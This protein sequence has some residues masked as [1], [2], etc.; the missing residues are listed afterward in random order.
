M[1]VSYRVSVIPVPSIAETLSGWVAGG[2]YLAA[3]RLGGLGRDSR[4]VELEAE[5]RLGAG[6]HRV[7]STA[8]LDSC[9]SALSQAAKSRCHRCNA[10]RISHNS[11]RQI[12]LN[13]NCIFLCEY[14]EHF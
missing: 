12:Q 8:S 1:L 10:V 3:W 2:A 13:P 4:F 9:M 6:T 11:E 5:E 7:D 14:F